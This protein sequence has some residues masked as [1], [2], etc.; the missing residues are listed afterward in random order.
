M[1]DRTTCELHSTAEVT[2]GLLPAMSW[3]PNGRHLFCAQSL[4]QQQQ[5][6]VS[7]P[8]AVVGVTVPSAAAAPTAAVPRG[9]VRAAAAAHRAAAVAAAGFGTGG[10]PQANQR[11]V[12]FERNGLQHGNFNLSGDGERRPTQSLCVCKCACTALPA[13]YTLGWGLWSYPPCTPCASFVLLSIL[14]LL[15]YIIYHYYYLL[16]SLH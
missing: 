5:Q 9:S 15:S 6:P 1:W 8:T 7:A 14:P 3:Q 12:L 13:R 16:C 2:P 4:D 10:G 11:V